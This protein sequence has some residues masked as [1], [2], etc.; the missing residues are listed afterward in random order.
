M[1][2]IKDNLNY[3]LSRNESVE[4]KWFTE[5]VI[6]YNTTFSSMKMHPEMDDLMSLCKEDKVSFTETCT[7]IV[8]QSSREEINFHNYISQHY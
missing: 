2:I 6:N 5:G 8:S 7:Y 1:V 3:Q 4:V